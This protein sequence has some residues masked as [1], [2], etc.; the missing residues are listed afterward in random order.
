MP[1]PVVVFTSSANRNL[2]DK[3]L[4]LGAVEFIE[5]SMFIEEFERAV[6]G[7]VEHWVN[8][9]NAA[10]SEVHTVNARLRRMPAQCDIRKDGSDP[11]E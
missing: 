6:N 2:R 9:G 10:G 5:K 4:T 1:A 8:S 7:M 3:V 11:L